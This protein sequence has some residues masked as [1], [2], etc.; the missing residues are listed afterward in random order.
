M[1]DPGI[2]TRSR[3]ILRDVDTAAA[4]EGL[5]KATAE[6]GKRSKLIARQLDQV[7]DR[8]ERFGKIL[9]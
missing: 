5:G 2:A 8:A 1:A 7:G 6:L 3:N 9:S 4:L